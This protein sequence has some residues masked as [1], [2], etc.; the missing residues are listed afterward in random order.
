M[1]LI[2]KAALNDLISKQNEKLKNNTENT[3]FSNPV[4]YENNERL[5]KKYDWGKELNYKNL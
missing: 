5:S 2:R 1:N 3:G 4:K